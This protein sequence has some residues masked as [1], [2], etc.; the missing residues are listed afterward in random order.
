MITIINYGSGNIQ[1]L[2]NIYNNLNIEFKVASTP[3]D[4]KDSTKIILPGVG[5]FDETIGMLKKSGFVEHLNHMVLINKI[6]VLGICVGMQIL[7]NESEEGKLKGLGW[8]NGSVRKFNKEIFD[9][10]PKIPHLGWNSIVPKNKQH[11]ILNNINPDRGFYFIHSYYFD[12]ND[13]NNILTE[14]FYGIK[15]CSSVNKENIYG[16]QFHPEKSHKNGIELLK[17][18]AEL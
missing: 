1:A 6:P 12:C 10:K 18:F 11:P 14:S 2:C 17:N 8:I 5:S 13:N 16:V 3:N 9:T 4:L 7:S 15:F